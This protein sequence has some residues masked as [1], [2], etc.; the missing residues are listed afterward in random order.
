MPLLEVGQEISAT[1]SADAFHF[2]SAHDRKPDK[3]PLSLN[4][5][6]ALTGENPANVEGCSKS[7]MHPESARGPI[8]SQCRSRRAGFGSG[9]GF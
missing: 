5:P 8:V 9:F 7:E 3:K 6:A 1:E 4:I 2:L